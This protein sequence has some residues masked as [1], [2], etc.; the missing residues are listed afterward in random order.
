MSWHQ[1]ALK[2]VEDCEKLGETVKRVLIPRF[3]NRRT[4]NP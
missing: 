3:P 4:L 1:E 2:G